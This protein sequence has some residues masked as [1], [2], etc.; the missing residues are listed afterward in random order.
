MGGVIEK[1]EFLAT[2]PLAIGSTDET[3]MEKTFCAN[4]CHPRLT[5]RA[6]AAKISSPSNP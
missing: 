5:G 3:L 1:I 2:V 4:L 6:G